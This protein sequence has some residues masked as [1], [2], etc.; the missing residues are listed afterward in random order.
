MSSPIP[1]LRRRKRTLVGC[2]LCLVVARRK[3][4][5]LE[6]PQTLTLLRKPLRFAF[7]PRFLFVV[8]NVDPRA[9]RDR[10]PRR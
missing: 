5:E 2:Q 1:G 10:E 7:G 9:L 3:R 6:Q 8:G 4:V